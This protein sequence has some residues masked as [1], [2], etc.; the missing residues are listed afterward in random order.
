MT[1]TARFRELLKTKMKDT[2]IS[3]VEAMAVVGW[4]HPDLAEEY[5]EEVLGVKLRHETISAP[6]RE[7]DLTVIHCA[8]RLS[9]L[10]RTRASEKG[11]PFRAAL[12]EVGREH[13]T[14]VGRARSEV[15]NDRG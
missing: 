3:L 11:I 5:R 12:S 1:A 14:L 8:E 2:R 6:G 4:E 10:A 9:E 13:P 7:Y 15:I